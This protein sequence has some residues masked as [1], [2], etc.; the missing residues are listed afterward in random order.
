MI[1]STCFLRFVNDFSVENSLSCDKIPNRN[2]HILDKNI[3]C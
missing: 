2:T 3:M 1:I